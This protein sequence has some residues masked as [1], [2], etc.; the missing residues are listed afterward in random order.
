MPEAPPAPEPVAVAMPVPAATPYAGAVGDAG[1]AP[2]ELDDEDED[3][4]VDGFDERWPY[5]IVMPGERVQASPRFVIAQ[6][7]QLVDEMDGARIDLEV[8]L[9]SEVTRGCLHREQSR[10]DAPRRNVSLCQ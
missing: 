4:E 2:G 7:C 6:L 9:G 1:P 3:D 5:E 10:S 8:D